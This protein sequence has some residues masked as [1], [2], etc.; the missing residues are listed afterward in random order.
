[1]AKTISVFEFFKLFPSE[2]DAVKFVEDQIWEN[3]PV[4]PHCGSDNTVPRPK[5][6]GHRCKDCREDFT[7]RHG[8]IFEKSRLSLVKWLYAIYLVQTSRK[9][10]SSLQL[11]KEL[12]ITQKTAWFLLHRI[13]EACKQGDWKLTNVVEMDA[14]YLGGK[15]KN[16]SNKKRKQL[17]KEQPGRGTVGKQPVIGMRGRDGR[18]KAVVVNRENKKTVRQLAKGNIEKGSV[19]CT[20][21]ARAYR[22]VSKVGFDHR[23]VN[24]S[25]KEYVNGMCHTNGIE[26][27]WALIKR[28][29]TGTFHH[30]S[31]KHCQRYVD[32]FTF[33][34]N[35]GNC[36]VDTID[37][38]KSV[39]AASKGKR[40]TYKAL[41]A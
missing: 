38:M 35:E 41:I 30:F 32:E 2:A 4:C 5:R 27:V 17:A 31:M 8:T 34:L 36:E 33:R 6:H 13:R 20:D 25:A 7:V 3:G 11:S 9:S 16:M 26:S 18:T 22:S 40:L 15:R 23:K 19:I 10:V 21:E 24:H 14:T 12:D 1:M 29:Y 39:C 28:G 37:R